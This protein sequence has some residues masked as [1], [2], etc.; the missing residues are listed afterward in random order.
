MKLRIGIGSWSWHNRLNFPSQLGQNEGN[1]VKQKAY[2]LNPI[3]PSKRGL[4]G[5]E[6][7]G[8]LEPRGE[9]T[10]GR[11]VYPSDQ[12]A[13]EARTVW[14]GPSEF[15]IWGQRARQGSDREELSLS[16]TYTLV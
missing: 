8:S 13:L 12:T 7:D 1:Y 4:L 15:G 9:G 10:L 3:I 14:N 5:L 11:A 6:R 2:A 16:I